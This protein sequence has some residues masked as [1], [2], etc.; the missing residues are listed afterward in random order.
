MKTDMVIAGGGIGEELPVFAI[1]ADGLTI[2]DALVG[3]GFAASRGEAKRLVSGGGA[4]IDGE[5]VS[6]ESY[7]IDASRGEVRISSGKKKHGVL[8]P[9]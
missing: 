4:R 5:A 9:S 8:R 6:D 3:I 7:R 1:P 2:V